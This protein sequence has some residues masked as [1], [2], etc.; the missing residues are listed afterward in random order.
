ME[1]LDAMQHRFAC[2]CYDEQKTVSDAQLK[3]ILEY[4]RL[5]PTSFGLELWSFHVVRSAEKKTALFHACF[6]QESVA[7]SAFTVAVMVRKAAFANPDGDLVH[8]RGKR[9][10]DPL[11]VFIADYRPYYDYLKQEGRLDCWLKSQGYLAVANM[12]TG[13]A[14]MGIQSCAIEGFHEQQVL[15]VLSLDG[16]QWQA[17]LLA[18]FGYPAEAERPKIRESLEDLVVFH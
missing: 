14:S 9:F 6:D 12:M 11:D 17:S 7:T 8:S 5:T 4:G 15:D 10:P 13:A 2:K 1:F 16:N 18:T 3:Q